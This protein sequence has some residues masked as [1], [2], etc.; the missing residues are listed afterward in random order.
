MSELESWTLKKWLKKLGLHKYKQAFLDNGYDT[1]D[2]CADLKKEDLDAVGVTNKHHRSTLFTQSKKLQELIAKESLE[3]EDGEEEVDAVDTR[4]EEKTSK[5]AVK[6]PP[7]LSLADTSQLQGTAQDLSDY[8][9]PWN[10]SAPNSQPVPTSP[11]PKVSTL[12]PPAGTP[13]DGVDGLSP[14]HRSGQPTAGFKVPSGTELPAFKGEKST[15]LTRLQLKLKIRE[16]L[17]SRGVVLSEPQYCKEVKSD[18]WRVFLSEPPHCMFLFLPLAN[19]MSA[20]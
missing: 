9:E 8:S 7:N 5:L 1:V 12:K 17:F 6:K 3:E 19:N 20:H 16:V 18:A 2:L 4:K 10:A 14:G 11:T 13:S 15:G